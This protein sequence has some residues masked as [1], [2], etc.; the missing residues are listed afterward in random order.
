MCVRINVVSDLIKQALI[1][2][3]QACAIERWGYCKEGDNE[4]VLYDVIMKNIVG[5]DASALTILCPVE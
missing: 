5:M 2:A 3:V 4:Y 1:E